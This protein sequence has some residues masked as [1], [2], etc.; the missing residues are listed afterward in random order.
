MYV[1][2]H[3]NMWSSSSIAMFDSNFSNYIENIYDEY[4][5]LMYIYAIL[6]GLLKLNI[7]FVGLRNY[8]F[9]AFLSR[10]ASFLFPKD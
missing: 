9:N 3:K 10:N 8:I 7:V 5:N 2:T 6:S 1:L 4:I